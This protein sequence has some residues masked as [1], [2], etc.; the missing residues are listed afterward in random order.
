MWMSVAGAAIQA[1]WAWRWERG[2][3]KAEYTSSS[4]VD[5][6]TVVVCL[7]NES[8]R[9]HT[10]AAGIQSALDASEKEGMRVNVVAVNHGSTDSTLPSL[11][12]VAELDPRWRVLSVPRS[13][14]GKK[15][16]LEAGVQASS[17][18]IVL[19]TD[20]DCT[21]VDPTWIRRMTTGAGENWD[22]NVGLSFPHAQGNLLQRLQ[23]L[24]ARRVAQRAVGAV[25]AGK[26]YL[27]FGRNLAFTRGMWNAVGGM[28]GHAELPSG[29][30]DLWV[31]QAARKGA[32]VTATTDKKAQ[33]VS[34]WPRTWTAWRRQ[35][36]R[37]FTASKAYPV[38][39]LLRL[40]APG[41]GWALL[42]AGV[43]HN[44][45][46]TSVGFMALS[47]GIR[48]LTFGMFLHQAGQPWREAWHLVWEPAVS[49]FRTWSWW[50]GST[51]ESTPWK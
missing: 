25:V 6:C 38:A 48:T 43:V 33:T 45:T 23:T 3:V 18:E 2:V 46:G 31:Q 34:E 17:G 21:P 50:K 14:S 27:G 19:V 51:S 11:D 9:V 7:H 35:K 4:R 47:M 39:V 26:P 28:K 42:L 40:A 15:E 32:R 44:P 10:L 24:E 22:V 12:R 8:E 30:D 16:A 1:W 5:S 13:T 37:H 36:T 41:L 29:D 20:A 49:A